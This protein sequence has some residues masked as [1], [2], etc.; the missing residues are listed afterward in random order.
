[1]ELNFE[2]GYRYAC[3]LLSR[4]GYTAC[5]LRKKIVSKE[6]PEDI[7]DMVLERCIERGYLND[8]TW[9]ES[10]IRIQQRKHYGK[11]RIVQGLKHKGIAI[12]IIEQLEEMFGDGREE[13]RYLLE[14]KY[15]A[16]DCS[17]YKQR[18]KV[19]AALMRRGFS[20]DI[21]FDMMP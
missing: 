12:E 4:H 11:K 20:S 8:K 10:Y 5:M 3:W 1:M 2:K 18:N 19:V 14:K 17:D 6:Y 9:A 16:I 7:A 21:I 13:I 15:A